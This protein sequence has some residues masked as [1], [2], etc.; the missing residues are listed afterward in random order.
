[1]RSIATT[2]AVVTA[3]SLLAG[4][5]TAIAKRAKDEVPAAVSTGKSV[6]CIPIT[7]IRESRVRND[8][9]IDFRM[10]GKKWY[11]NTLPLDCPSLGFEERFSYTTSL[12]QLCS[13]DI[14]TVLRTGGAGGLDRGPS[15]GLGKFEP[16]EI[17]RAPRTM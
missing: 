3:L 7:Q 13:Q 1:M 14:I 5:S 4:G 8:R 11:R 6:S 10:S 12:S 9:V 2:T 17:T 16:V 15:C